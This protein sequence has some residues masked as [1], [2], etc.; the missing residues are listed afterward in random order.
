M[1][2]VAPTYV[3]FAFIP[4]LIVFICVQFNIVADLPK[5][6]GPIIPYNHLSSEKYEPYLDRGEIPV[7]RTDIH[8]ARKWPHVRSCLVGSESKKDHPDLRK[9][10]W[11]KLRTDSDINV[12]MFRIFNSLGT[13]E[14]NERW[15]NE[16]GFS[17]SIINI[18]NEY[19]STWSSVQGTRKSP[20]FGGSFIPSK[21]IRSLFLGSVSWSESFSASWN[22]SGKLISTSHNF[23]YH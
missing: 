23:I 12:C 22:K 3:W 14:R 9:I 10:N 1:K 6:T 19:V 18:H 5:I 15:F 16:Q 11:S 7:T 2:R 20:K 21:G 13:K 8:A 4:L 17:S